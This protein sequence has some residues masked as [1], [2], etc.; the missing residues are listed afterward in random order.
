MIVAT[1]S[2]SEE[3][4]KQPTFWDAI[5]GPAY[6]KATWFCFGLALFHQNTGLNAINVYSK[7]M[8]KKLN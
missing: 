3:G 2:S 5:T 8:V 4:G 1:T 7:T 6:R